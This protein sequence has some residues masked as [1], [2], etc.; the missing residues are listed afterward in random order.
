[1]VTETEFKL[2]SDGQ[3]E[4]E[5]ESQEQLNAAMLQLKNLTRADGALVQLT[6]QDLGL[7]RTILSASTEE[8]KEQLMWRMADFVDEDEA[9]DHVAAYYEAKELGMDT[10]FNVAFMFALC[11]ANRKYNRTNLMAQI[12]DTLSHQKITSNAPR[13]KNAGNTNPRSPLSG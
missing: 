3:E 7:L 5:P 11:S 9:L 2:K 8:F 1:M 4:A 13:Y 12:F 10:G 6:K